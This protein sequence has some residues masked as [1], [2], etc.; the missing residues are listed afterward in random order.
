MLLH[1]SGTVLV[2]LGEDLPQPLIDLLAKHQ[3]EKLFAPD[4]GQTE[5][6][7]KHS[8]TH[9][10]IPVTDLKA[11]TK[12]D[13]EVFDSDGKLLLKAGTEVAAT[14]AGSLQR[15]GIE[16]IFLRKPEGEAQYK[17]GETLRLEIRKLRRGEST[18]TPE[19][20]PKIQ[21]K[22]AE[23]EK[24]ELKVAAADDLEVEKLKNKIDKLATM[25][26]AK[27]GVSLEE[28]VRDTRKLGMASDEEKAAF[29]GVIDDSLKAT[30]DIFDHLSRASGKTV[31]DTDAI[32][33]IVSRAMGGMI[34][35]RELLILCGTQRNGTNY[36]VK[37][38]VATAVL[39][40]NIASRLGFGAGQ[41]KAV[42]YGALLQDVGML[43]IPSSILEKTGELTPREH[44]EIRRHPAN[45]L[46][47]LQRIRNIPAEVTYN[48]Y[49]SH[50]RADGSGYPC[51]KS[52]IVIHTFAKI[53]GVAD[54]YAAVCA[55]RPY[56]EAKTPY[57]AM[58]ALLRM[59]GK[60]QL[61][62]SVVR[63]F[64]QCNSLYAI[65]S[66]VKL[67]DG[68]IGRVVCANPEDYMRPIVNLL[69]DQSFKPLSDRSRFDLRENPDVSI[70][71]AL[72]IK[73][74]IPVEE[75]SLIGF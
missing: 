42:G 64:L 37:H 66:F 33:G 49:Q 73:D 34:Q 23:L 61:N 45:G 38:A 46:D 70:T 48:V 44:A 54:I 10:T 53:V 17:L 8:L 6:E 62:A 4:N 16:A 21:E 60:R 69:W 72:G 30:A 1:Q 22:A 9:T 36:M 5:E 18:D 67:S 52:D 71:Q 43:K 7:A 15:R 31:I 40:V 2:K 41:T 55:N 39:A 27:E 35:R 59:C 57:E 51:G 32:N 74:G 63:A 11:G 47:I 68:R 25:E 13:R 26:V 28:Q 24:I 29:S 3:V 58:E 12:L 75:T 19:A 14:L 65:G 56:R 20:A 50:E